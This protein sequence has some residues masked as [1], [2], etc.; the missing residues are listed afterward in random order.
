MGI[1]SRVALAVGLPQRARQR[2]RRRIEIRR[3]KREHVAHGRS[4]RAGPRERGEVPV[5][6]HVPLGVM[7]G[8]E[9]RAQFRRQRDRRFAHAE[10]RKH[11]A[12][13]E[14]LIAH[15][16]LQGEHVPQQTHAEVRVLVFGAH[17]ARQLIARQERV[18]LRHAVVGVRVQRIVRGKV[19]RHA[20]KPRD[21]R[22]QVE[23]RDLPA[24]PRRHVD[25]S[26]QEFR[27]GVVE[28]HLTARDHV[29][30]QRCGE[31][32][33]D[34]PDLEHAVR[35]HPDGDDAFAAGIAQADHDPA[36]LTDPRRQHRPDRGVGW[37][38]LLRGARDA[39][40]K[41]GDEMHARI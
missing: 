7:A 28:L 16:R 17:V 31:D 11:S 41:G 8:R 20:G 3:E 10:R 29:G 40:R 34:G 18:H 14:V 2:R 27:D 6:H 24:V 13:H 9:P 26:G 39:Q 12:G 25:R 1:T 22:C 15:P 37:Q 32:L 36:L 5:G 35:R 19:G 38:R 33:R 4:Q 23:Q 21:L 30:Q